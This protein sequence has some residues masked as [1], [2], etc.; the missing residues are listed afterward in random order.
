MRRPVLKKRNELSPQELHNQQCEGLF[1]ENGS[2]ILVPWFL[3][4]SFLYYH[5]GVS[6]LT[7]EYYD[8]VCGRLLADYDSLTHP[9]ARLIS[10]DDLKAGTGYRLKLL[11]YPL[12]TRGAATHLA[13]INLGVV[14]EPAVMEYITPKAKRPVLR[15]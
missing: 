12:V 4:A 11:D 14:F 9:H 2:D 6:L 1:E 13:N 15:R 10:R 8:G 5:C 3:M 7:D